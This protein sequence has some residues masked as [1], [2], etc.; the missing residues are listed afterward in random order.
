[1]LLRRIVFPIEWQ[2]LIFTCL[3]FLLQAD[4]AEGGAGR[5][6]EET[7]S[8]R[9]AIFF[10]FFLVLS[11]LLEQFFH[12]L[13]HCLHH[14]GQVGLE[15][16]VHKIKEELMLMGFISLMLIALEEKIVRVCVEPSLS[17]EGIYCCSVEAPNR[18]WFDEKANSCCGLG[19]FENSSSSHR[20]LGASSSLECP[21]TDAYVACMNDTV[22]Q[23][24]ELGG[25]V[26]GSDSDMLDVCP[27]PGQTTHHLPSGQH[28]F[29]VS[30]P[31]VLLKLFRDGC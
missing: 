7:A 24:E 8:Y 9:V 30:S 20:M 1:M 29:E 12:R 3:L 16:A 13:E 28:D 23:W 5:N 31:L 6:I 18:S 22:T 11:F 15:E 2:T 4:V 10:I 14:I 19:A 27:A 17:P 26:P 25:Y 21:L